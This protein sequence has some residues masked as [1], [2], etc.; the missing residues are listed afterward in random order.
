MRQ[1]K[2]A[3]GSDLRK[4][5][6]HVIAPHEYE[7]A[8]EL[9]DEQL[10]N[11]VVSVGGKRRDRPTSER[12]KQEVKLRLDTDVISTY[13]ATG[14]GWE[15][16]MNTDLRRARKLDAPKRRKGGGKAALG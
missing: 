8:P 6:L 9:T 7:E 3:I 5:D 10:T 1:S 14:E 16:R 15:A 12:Q 4:V 2:P 13:R 11:A